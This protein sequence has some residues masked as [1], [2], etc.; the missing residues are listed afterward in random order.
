MSMEHEEETLQAMRDASRQ[1]DALA[2]LVASC[3]LQHVRHLQTTIS[4]YFQKDFIRM[5]P[6]EVAH[7]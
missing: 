5:L 7:A 3:S 6:K 1:L 2:Y 4:P